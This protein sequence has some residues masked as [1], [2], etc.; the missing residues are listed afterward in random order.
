VRGTVRKASTI[1]LSAKLYG[2]HEDP[3]LI[4]VRPRFELYGYGIREKG[5]K[6]T[7]KWRKIKETYMRR[8]A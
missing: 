3:L 1:K 2:E 5:E 6:A 7:K 4:K 8:G